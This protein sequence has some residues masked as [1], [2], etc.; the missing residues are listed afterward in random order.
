MCQRLANLYIT[1]TAACAII[2]TGVE[3]ESQS[4]SKDL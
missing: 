1:N 4:E 2:I 3:V